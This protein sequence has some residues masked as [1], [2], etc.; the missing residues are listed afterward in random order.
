MVLSIERSLPRRP[1]HGRT[2][3]APDLRP[4]DIALAQLIRIRS[5]DERCGNAN[6]GCSKTLSAVPTL[7]LGILAGPY[8]F[9]LLQ[10]GAD[11][12]AEIRS[13]ANARVGLDRQLQRAF[14]FFLT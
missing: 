7:W 6:R 8:S 5:S 2:Y 12:F 11:S 13:G 14:Q 1:A 10:E 3:A 4:R 9:A